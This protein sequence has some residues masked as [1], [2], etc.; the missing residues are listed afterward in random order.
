MEA[1]EDNID[2]DDDDA[3]NIYCWQQ[4]VTKK[5]GRPHWVAQH[6]HICATVV[7]SWGSD[8][9]ATIIDIVGS[10]VGSLLDHTETNHDENL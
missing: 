5:Q 6:D 8:E 1:A 10:N 4:S 9:D 2:D 3:I 7:W